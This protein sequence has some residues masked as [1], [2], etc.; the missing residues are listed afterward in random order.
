MLL[1]TTCD[2]MRAHSTSWKKATAPASSISGNTHAGPGNCLNEYLRI[3]AGA[4]DCGAASSGIALCRL[5]VRHAPRQRDGE[6]EHDGV[7][8]GSDPDRAPEPEL[9][10]QHERGEQRAG[11][12][13][14]GVHRVQQA[15]AT[16]D[17]RFFGHRVTRQHGQRGAH[18]RGGQR[19][20]DEGADQIEESGARM[21]AVGRRGLSA[22]QALQRGVREPQQT[23]ARR[24]WRCR[25]CRARAG[26]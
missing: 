21:V 1:P 18:E 2:N 14:R 19:Q 6:Q 20:R 16:A 26:A 8:R 17:L 25:R 12:G 9:G 24:R 3:R 7:E 10:Q 22:E 13:A 11:D 23:P 5:L 15:D 4:A